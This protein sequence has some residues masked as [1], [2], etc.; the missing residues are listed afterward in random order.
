MTR[1]GECNDVMKLPEQTRS[2]V[3]EIEDILFE[4][5]DVKLQVD[6]KGS[7]FY[8]VG[9]RIEIEWFVIVQAEVIF[10]CRGRYQH[11]V[12]GVCAEVLGQSKV[13]GGGT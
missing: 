12:I 4:I 5:V 6:I 2:Y 10:A 3:A 8:P 7:E 9:K 1:C 11:C 13:H